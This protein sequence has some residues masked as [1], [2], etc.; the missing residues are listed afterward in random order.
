[1]RS[2]SCQIEFAN[3]DHT[4]RCGKPAIADCAD[5]GTPICDDC[6]MECCEES[7]CEY[8]YDYHVTYSCVLR[9]HATNERPHTS[10][11]R[12]DEDAA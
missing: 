6:R 1:M 3:E 12:T 8:C 11:I 4:I 10:L 9:K 2:S 5:C 7:F